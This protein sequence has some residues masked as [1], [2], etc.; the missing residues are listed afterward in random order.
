MNIFTS[1]FTR[2]PNRQSWELQEPGSSP[3]EGLLDGAVRPERAYRRQAAW[4]RGLGRR[5]LWTVCTVI[6]IAVIAL[7]T[8]RKFPA[9]DPGPYLSAQELEKYTGELPW[10]RA[11]NVDGR[12]VFWW[13][14]F[15]E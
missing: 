15:P 12:E 3:S 11:H 5:K 2:K 1:L 8:W 7:T 10:G 13:E 6:V 4:S 9:D 14:Q